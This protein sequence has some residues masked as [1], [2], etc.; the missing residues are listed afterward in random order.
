MI[1]II[2]YINFGFYILENA[3]LVILLRKKKSFIIVFNKI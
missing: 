3:N 2:I 1:F